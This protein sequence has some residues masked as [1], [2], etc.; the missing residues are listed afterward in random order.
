MFQKIIDKLCEYH[1]IPKISVK[2][3]DSIDGD[4]AYFDSGE[5]EIVI[6]RDATPDILYHE[7]THYIIHILNRAESLEEFVC[8]RSSE[9]IGEYIE[10]RFPELDSKIRGKK[11]K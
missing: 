8:W 7:F 3:V 6:E 5:F 4:E 2:V 9:S 11:K 1:E 10:D